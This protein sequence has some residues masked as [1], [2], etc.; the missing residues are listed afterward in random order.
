MTPLK[1]LTAFC[2]IALFWFTPN[3]ALADARFSCAVDGLSAYVLEDTS[4]PDMQDCNL[5]SYDANTNSFDT[6]YVAG[7]MCIV[8]SLMAEAMFSMYCEIANAV[9]PVL[10]ALLMLYVIIYGI[11]ISF[12]LVRLEAYD[13]IMRVIRIG[14]I[15]AV[16]TDPEMFYFWVYDFTMNIFDGLSAFLFELD[17]DNV[18]VPDDP[19]ASAAEKRLTIF[20]N[21]D[22]LFDMMLGSSY[23]VGILV[24]AA[25]FFITGIGIP[26]SLTL[27]YAMLAALWAFI[28]ILYSYATA[29]LALTFLLMFTPIF[30]TLLLFTQTQRFF[31][32][33]LASVINFVLQPVLVL[34]FIFLLAD[35]SDMA[36]F[37]CGIQ[38]GTAD[39]TCSDAIQQAATP[40][41][42]EEG[43]YSRDLG[44]T[45]FNATFPQI[46]DPAEEEG[47][48][49]LP[50]FLSMMLHGLF[51]SIAFLILNLVA[52]NFLG[53]VPSI[54]QELSQYQGLTAA[55]IF[56]QP[57]YAAPGGAATSVEDFGEALTKPMRDRVAKRLTRRDGGQSGLEAVSGAV[58]DELVENPAVRTATAPTRA[59]IKGAKKAGRAAKNYVNRRSLRRGDRNNDTS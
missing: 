13:F 55:P 11:A 10:Q 12:G 52:A 41:I 33:W 56:T 38:Y 35:I 50:N 32:T 47:S 28:R 31:F 4:L 3:L 26:F 21:V 15:Y 19:N 48:S 45:T 53:K 29:I 20:E 49:G 43:S 7:T 14:L 27:F 18:F 57:A 25:A 54:A 23:M 42:I 46:L 24:M 51:Y 6:H 40:I 58:A 59:A 22:T 36:D 9:K 5:I 2:L 1:Q 39:Q 16:A 34:V 30:I 37:L 17:R 8:Q 44:V